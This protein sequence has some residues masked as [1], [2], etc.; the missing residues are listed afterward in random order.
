MSAWGCSVGDG[1][2]VIGLGF[3]QQWV[4]NRDRIS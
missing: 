1:S 3:W 4:G 2:G